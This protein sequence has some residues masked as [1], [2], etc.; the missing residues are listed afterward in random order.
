MTSSAA[1]LPAT[2]PTL[3]LLAEH[4]RNLEQAGLLL[5]AGACADDPLELIARYRNLE[6]AV[7][8]HME[9]EEEILP[10]YAVADPEDAAMI[11]T[12]H[13]DLRRQ[14]YKIGVDVE[15]HR[16]RLEAIDQLVKA[17]QVHAA[18]EDRGMYVWAQASLPAQHQRA[19]LARIE[20]SLHKLLSFGTGR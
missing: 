19:I 20:E 9:A 8:A 3:A 10:A 15:L 6:H 1:R 13:E 12:W 16:V 7:L 4:H 2:L 14:L 5:R 17:L 11:R 18:H